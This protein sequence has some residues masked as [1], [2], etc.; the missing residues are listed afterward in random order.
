MTYQQALQRPAALD[1]ATLQ[2]SISVAH[3]PPPVTSTPEFNMFLRS[4]LPLTSASPD[5][6]RQYYRGSVPQNRIWALPL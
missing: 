1:N 3:N 2:E 5:S 4:P 6:L